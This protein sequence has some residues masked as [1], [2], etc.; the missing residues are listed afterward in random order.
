MMFCIGR[1]ELFQSTPLS[2]RVRIEIDVSPV[3]P[4]RNEEDTNTLV[5]IT[6]VSV[7]QEPKKDDF[8]A[9]EISVSAVSL[10]QGMATLNPEFGSLRGDPFV[11]DSMG[12]GPVSSDESI[13]SSLSDYESS[14]ALSSEGEREEDDLYQPLSFSSYEHS[15][16]G[17]ATLTAIESCPIAEGKSVVQGHQEEPVNT[18]S[19]VLPEMVSRTCQEHKKMLQETIQKDFKELMKGKSSS[20]KYQA[21]YE[22][23]RVMV[24]VEKI[25]PLFE[26][27]CGSKSCGEKNEVVEQK[28]EAGVLTVIYQCKNGHRCVWHSSKVLSIKGGQKVFVSST[29]LAA[30]TLI[31][32]NNFE[33]ISL[34]ASSLNINF[35]SS[36]TFHRIQTF[37]VV[38]SIKELWVEMKGKIWNLF[39]KDHLV[40]CGD[41]RMDSPGFSAKY[42]LYT[43]MD[44]FLDLIVDVE[45]VD[46]REASGTSS[47]ME[48]MGCKRILERM[49][50]VLNLQ[51]LV[52]DASSVIMKMVRELKSQ[53][54]EVLEHFF[55]S[56]DV[57]HKSV[58]L[59][60]KVSAA[61]KIKGCEA[62]AQWIEPIRNHFWHCTETCDGDLSKLKEMWI[63]VIHHVCGEHEWENGE[64]SHGQLTDVEEGK[65]I[66]AKDSKAAEE[67]RKIVFD[68]EWLKSLQHY[69]RFRHTSKLENFNSMCLKYA[70]KR[71]AFSYE[72]FTGRCLLAVLDHNFHL[73]RKT[74]SGKF[75]KLYSKRSGNW[76]AEAVKEDKSYSYWPAL[77][78]EILCK[79]AEDLETA[80][81]HVTVSPT[82][83]QHLAPTIAMR[84]S[85]T[86][87]DLVAARLSRFKQQK[88]KS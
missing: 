52:T 65:E 4:G 78:A 68:A 23:A 69:V 13:D 71:I 45:V 64:C 19:D 21:L 63:G 54:C 3:V 87:G 88:Q 31:T 73:F 39:E 37:Y 17:S 38:P 48:K 83:P 51:E 55:H 42:C 5:D 80:A 57:W 36:T 62:L 49:V 34:F 14:D 46:K 12:S 32:G 41:G 35:I 26:V 47:L 22:G 79:R 60:A 85:P 50:G 43:M 28:L 44:H 25:L 18:C 81:R 66:L 86:T 6:G 7:G 75:K 77:F 27:P 2:K 58:K 9:Q 61:S 67:L 15:V 70:S 74:I 53:N 1:R 11:D 24:D 16:D 59:T 82:N 8:L 29:L 20:L 76:R 56:L 40:L 10:V 72:V 30:A 33:K 84:E